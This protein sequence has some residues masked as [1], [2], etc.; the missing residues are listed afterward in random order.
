MTWLRWIPAGLA[1]IVAAALTNPPFQITPMLGG[2]VV[3]RLNVWTGRVDLCTPFP[4]IHQ[5]VCRAQAKVADS[6][7]VE[8][9]ASD[10]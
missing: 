4:E 6:W 8:D 2:Q 9:E 10:R 1:L 7:S 3:A 5:F